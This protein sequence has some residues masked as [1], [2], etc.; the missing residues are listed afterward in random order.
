MFTLLYSKDSLIIASSKGIY[1]G[2]EPLCIMSLNANV[3]GTV[4][5]LLLCSNVDG[6]LGLRGLTVNPILELLSIRILLS[7]KKGVCILYFWLSY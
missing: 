1:K 5:S 7:S 4:R 3:I 6:P 2:S